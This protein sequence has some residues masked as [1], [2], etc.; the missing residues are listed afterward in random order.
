MIASLQKLR[1]SFSEAIRNLRRDMDEMSALSGTLDG[2]AIAAAGAKGSEAPPAASNFDKELNLDKELFEAFGE[3]AMTLRT[4]GGEMLK[5]SEETASPETTVAPLSDCMRT[6][7]NITSRTNLLALNAAMEGSRAGEAGRGFAVVAEDVHRLAEES[8]AASR[9]AVELME[10]LDAGTSTA[11][12]STRETAGRI[13]GIVSK[14]EESRKTL[15][16]SLAR[17]S[18]VNEAVRSTASVEAASIAGSAARASKTL[19]DLAAGLESAMS[20]FKIE[21]PQENQP[22]PGGTETAE[23]A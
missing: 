16:D 21:E 12:E 1:R 10:K 23:P 22:N 6:I 8:G 19:S 20:G 2:L 17:T 7:D 9:R 14:M 4:L 5:N 3:F 15:G 18:R 11:I 13:F